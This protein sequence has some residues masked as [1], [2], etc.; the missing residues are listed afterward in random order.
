MDEHLLETVSSFQNFADR[1]RS[2]PTAAGRWDDVVNHI[3]P[4]RAYA[5]ALTLD[6]ATADDLVE[7]TLLQALKKSNA[8]GPETHLR[9]WLFTALHDT[10]HAAH[11][12]PVESG[13]ASINAS[14]SLDEMAT[15]PRLSSSVT[16][17]S[18]RLAFESL[19]L[20]QREALVLTGPGHLSF[21]HAAA[22]CGCSVSVLKKCASDGRDRLAASCSFAHDGASRKS[23]R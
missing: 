21:Y 4:M 11:A 12:A 2:V 15:K 7:E 6:R 9:V 16:A 20:N 5:L 19:P 22:V 10:F 1:G 23:S 17:E 18:F 3:G 13:C 14:D 8:V